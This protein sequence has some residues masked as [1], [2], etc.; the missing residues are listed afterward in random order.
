MKISERLKEISEFIS[1]EDKLIDIGCDHALLDIY[2]CEQYKDLKVIASDIHEGALNNAI[3]NVSNHNLNDRISLRL[4]DGLSIVNADEID[5][6]LISGMGFYTIQDILSNA[7]KMVNVKK[8]VVQSN[9]DVVKLRK[10]IIKLGF[11]IV[12]EKLVK[13]NDIIY[14]IIEFGL[15]QEKYTYDEIYFGPRILENKDDLFYEYYSKKLLKY[16]NLLLQIPKYEIKSKLHHKKLIKI[17]R[18][19][20]TTVEN[21]VDVEEEK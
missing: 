2:L 15:G 1:P 17:I 5:T 3:K 16:E 11:K 12:K 21:K 13:D 8:I 20:L 14:T 7:P 10:F 19:A 18:R 4:G 6:I 9:T